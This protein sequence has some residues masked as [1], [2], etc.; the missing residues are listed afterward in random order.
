LPIAG[1]KRRAQGYTVGAGSRS[2][3][4]RQRRSGFDRPRGR[5]HLVQ[6]VAFLSCADHDARLL[7]AAAEPDWA[8]PVPHCPEWDA[9]ELVRHTGGILGWITAVVTSGERVS[10]R[11]LPT[12]PEGLNELGP[13]Y[14][15]SLAR[16]LDV[17][18]AAD[19]AAEMWTFSPTGDRTTGWWCRR[20]AIEVAIHRWD[21]EHAVA[22]AGGDAPQPI[23]GD[24]AAAGIEEFFLEFLPRLLGQDGVSGI[25]GTLHLQASE[26]PA[27]W[28]VDLDEGGALLAE[29]AE[30]GTTIRGTRSDLLLWLMNRG[31]LDSL[32]TSGDIDTSS[33]SQLRL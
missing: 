12:A 8:R 10:R 3:A 29:S 23:D 5:L 26:D 27:S 24:A 17:L 6:S 1:A 9:A 31:P 16:T 18:S 25:A 11:D 13:W 7:L 33:W 28:W 19:P 32:E 21:I 30:A 22:L 2:G 15:A 4:N 20:L 14:L